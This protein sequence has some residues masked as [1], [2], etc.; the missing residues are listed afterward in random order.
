MNFIKDE[1]GELTGVI[2]VQLE[3]VFDKDSGRYIMNQIEGSEQQLDAQLVLIAAGFLGANPDIVKIFGVET[4]KRT[5]VKC[6][7]STHQTSVEKVFAA[8]DMHL[9]QSLVVR[10]IREGRD[11]AKEV[12]K[13]LMG[14]TN[15]I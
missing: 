5:N 14:Y 15:L 13:Y 4:D 1:N 12:D 7:G 9:G 6:E 10:A 2:T 3:R 11:A 8:G